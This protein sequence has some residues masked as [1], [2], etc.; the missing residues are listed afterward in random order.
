MR[1]YSH[2]ASL[3]GNLRSLI[4]KIMLVGLLL[5]SV[6]LIYAEKEQRDWI[7]DARQSALRVTAPIAHVLGSPVRAA[8]DLASRWHHFWQ[9]YSLNRQLTYDNEQLLQ[10]RETALRLEA[11]NAAL[12][13]LLHYQPASAPHFISAK[14]IGSGQGSALSKRITINVG[15]DEGIRKHMPAITG[16]GLVGR[17]LS[18]GAHQSEVLLI[19]DVSSRIPVVLQPSGERALLIGDHD[20]LPYLKLANPKQEPALGEL[21]MTSDDGSLLPEGLRIGSLFA[22]RDGRFEVLPDFLDAPLHYVRLVDRAP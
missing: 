19:T 1:Y 2:S 22:A 14:V 15:L 20:G 7:T 11:E 3:A 9:L 17:T 10:W 18:V 12:R 21:V 16:H 13:H 4:R 5:A 8:E 6:A